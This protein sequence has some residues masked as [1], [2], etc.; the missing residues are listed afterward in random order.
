[1]KNSILITLSILFA[2]SSLFCL[3]PIM[4]KKGS[5]V[6]ENDFSEDGEIDKVVWNKRQN[7][8]WDVKNGVMHGIESTKEYQDSKKDH[9]GT[10]PRLNIKNTPENFVIEFEI[11]FKDG[12][13]TTR[14][15]FVEFGHHFARVRFLKAGI[16]LV[17]DH[18]SIIVSQSE[19]QLELGKTYHCLAERMNDQFIM[20]IKDGPTLFGQHPN[21]S[22]IPKNFAFGVAGTKNGV[23]EIDNV[24]LWEATE[25]KTSWENSKSSYITM[26]PQKIEKPVKVKKK[27][28]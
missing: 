24:K 25:F 6:Y 13:E 17:A 7:T 27:K 23:I 12:V 15:P 1:M 20:Q 3:D 28:T 21:F 16:D 10:E 18:E 19:A 9:K 22:K 2:T 14:S 5:L 26:E 4:V 11:T 8:R